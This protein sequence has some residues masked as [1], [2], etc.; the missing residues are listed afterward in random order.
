MR[1]GGR[2]STRRRDGLQFDH[3]CQFMRVRAPADAQDAAAHD[4]AD[5]MQLWQREGDW[6]L[7]TFR[8]T[9]CSPAAVCASPCCRLPSRLQPMPML[10]WHTGAI[11]QWDS[12]RLGLLEASTS[13]FTPRT[14][15]QQQQQQQSV[16]GGFCR[17][18]A[19]GDI[20]VG[21]PSMDALCTA[22]AAQHGDRLK[23][24]WNSKV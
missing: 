3:G 7:L 18:L 24:I 4:F 5:Q 12:S 10:P 1:A 13:Q 15:L 2:A 20:F 23:R 19:P 21:A 8:D 16:A 22:L 14:A 17:L 11:A 6:I 9:S